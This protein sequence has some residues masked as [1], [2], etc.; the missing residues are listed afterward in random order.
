MG[1]GSDV[2]LEIADMTLMRHDLRLV[3]SAIALA[4]RTQSVIKSN[5]FWAFGYNLVAIPIAMSG[6]LNPM[7]AAGAMAFSSLSVVLNSLRLR[8]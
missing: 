5:L 7:I 2:A 1:G 6:R 8:R 3:A 4:R